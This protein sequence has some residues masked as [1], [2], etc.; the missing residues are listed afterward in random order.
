M[1]GKCKWCRKI[2]ALI[3]IEEGQFLQIPI[4]DG[5][6]LLPVTTIHIACPDA[7]FWEQ[8]ELELKGK[9]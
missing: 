4:V 6:I 5:E 1:I 2:I 8:Y 3:D 7:P 9:L